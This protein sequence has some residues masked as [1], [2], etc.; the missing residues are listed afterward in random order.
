MSESDTNDKPTYLQLLVFT[1]CTDANSLSVHLSRLNFGCFLFKDLSD[2]QGLGV[3]AVANDPEQIVS[4][5]RDLLSQRLFRVLMLRHERTMTARTPAGGGPS[6][7]E[8]EAMLG[9]EEW[10]WAMWYPMR[11][12]AS[13]SDLDEHLKGPV[14]ERMIDSAGAK[15]TDF[16]RVLLRSHG[17]DAHGNEFMQGLHGSDLGQLSRVVEAS[18]QTP[19][20]A[21]YVASSGPFFVGRAIHK[22][23]IAGTGRARW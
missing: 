9:N 14:F 2:P 17:L 3:L 22:E 12:T 6:R 13:L 16:G 5:L 8:L 18:R 11:G 7:E 21:E 20:H 1:D 10:P 15:R 23:R 19:L 4:D